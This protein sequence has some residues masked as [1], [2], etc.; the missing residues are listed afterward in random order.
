MHALPWLAS[1]D[2]DG[3]IL[4]V[5]ELVVEGGGKFERFKGICSGAVVKMTTKGWGHWEI[6]TQ[7]SRGN[8]RRYYPIFVPQ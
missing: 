7:R 3:K 6:S 4:I 1:L 5:V 2:V 8:D